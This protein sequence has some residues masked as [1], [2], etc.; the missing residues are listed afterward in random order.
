MA[1]IDMTR[2]RPECK[3]LEGRVELKFSQ[4]FNQDEWKDHPTWRILPV[5]K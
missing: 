1:V 2:D 3:A 5:S 4:D